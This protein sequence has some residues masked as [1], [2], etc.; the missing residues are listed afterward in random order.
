M[1]S[2]RSNQSTKDSKFFGVLAKAYVDGI[3]EDRE[4]APVGWFNSALFGPLYGI[5]K[6]MFERQ[7]VMVEDSIKALKHDFNIYEDDDSETT[8]FHIRRRKFSSFIHLKRFKF[9]LEVEGS[10]NWR[11]LR[12][13]HKDRAKGIMKLRSEFKDL[14]DTIRLLQ[15]RKNSFQCWEPA[16]N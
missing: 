10:L 3:G 9:N 7:R 15:K 12:K 14:N 8:S 13:D 5:S 6:G 1:R 4:M 16:D 2:N 11:L